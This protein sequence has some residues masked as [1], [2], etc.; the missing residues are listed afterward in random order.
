M[1]RARAQ[2]KLFTFPPYLISLCAA[3]VRVECRL[4]VHGTCGGE[5]WGGEGL[6][7]AVRQGRTASAVIVDVQLVQ[8]REREILQV[9]LCEK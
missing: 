5:H 8:K 7:S 6:A 3:A 1:H 9:N 4:Y 2:T